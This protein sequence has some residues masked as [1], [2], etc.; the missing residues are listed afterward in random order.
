MSVAEAREKTSTAWGRRHTILA[1]CVMA[2]FIA[3]TDRVNISVAVVAMR[4]EF[5]WTQTVKGLVLSSFFIGYM[6]FMIPGGWLAIRYGGRVVLAFAVGWWSLFTLLT[7]SAASNSLLA[8][9]GARIALGVGEACLMPAA[10]DLFSRWVPAG[11]R[12]RATT[13]FASGA[14]LGQIAGF[15]AAGWLTGAYGWPASFYVFGAIGCLWSVLC[16]TYV[17]DNPATDRRTTLQE[18]ELLG[19]GGPQQEPVAR[20]SFRQFAFK[21]P[22]WA[23]LLCHFGSNWGLYLLVSWLPSY[24]RDVMG[25]GFTTAGLYSAA[26]WVSALVAG[27][28]AAA[29]ADS[30]VTRG[31]SLILVRKV[32]VGV[33]L[34]GFALFLLLMREVHTPGAALALVCAATGALGISWSGFLPNMLDVLPRQSGMLMAVSNTLAAIPGIA[35]VAVTGW[36]LDRTG[37]YSVTFLLTATIAVAGTLVYF[38]FATDRSLED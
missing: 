18:I 25:L 10:Y 5:G 2:M 11:E 8:L 34:L 21:A 12:S 27:N 38:L 7:P 16:L 28:L 31:V 6:V 17:S 37:S 4:T 26:P 9:V 35:G 36:L 22:V 33:G 30:A 32:T 24:F 23:I 15:A 3:Y 13:R 1:L 19:A 20:A 29:V 14:P